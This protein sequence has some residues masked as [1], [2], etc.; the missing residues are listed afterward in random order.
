MR[1]ANEGAKSAKEGLT[2]GI[3]P[4]RDSDVSPAVDVAVFTDTGQARNNMIVLSADVVVACGME[5]AGTASEV[6]LALKNGKPV[7]LMAAG[8]IAEAFFSEIGKGTVRVATTPDEA[9]S[10]VTNLV[11]AA[12]SK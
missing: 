6:A 1:A 2:I 11:D 3:L 4:Y 10:I 12:R 7:V 8:D 5:G 9:L